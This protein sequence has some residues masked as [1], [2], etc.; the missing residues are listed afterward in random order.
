MPEFT[1]PATW[2]DVKSLARYFE[3]EGVKYA[4]IGGYG[5]AVHG[6]SRFTEDVRRM[7]K[8]SGARWM[9]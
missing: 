7:L 8:P 9:Y 4:I 2:E 1:R 3:A 6:L 5:L